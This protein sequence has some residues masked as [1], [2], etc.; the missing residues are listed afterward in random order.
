MITEMAA[1]SSS[2]DG[3]NEPSKSPDLMKKKSFMMSAR[4]GLPVNEFAP[5]SSSSSL[6]SQK[7]QHKS[8]KCPPTQAC[9]ISYGADLYAENE[10]HYLPNS[11]ETYKN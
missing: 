8:S 7:K 2:G 4:F 3:R 9:E 11:L 5:D 10:V 1:S 6:K